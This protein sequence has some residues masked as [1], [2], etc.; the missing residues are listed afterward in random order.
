MPDRVAF[1]RVHDL[2]NIDLAWTSH[3]TVVAGGAEP[4]RIAIEHLLLEISI[5]HTDEPAR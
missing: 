4:V 5:D 3:R 2:G 1:D